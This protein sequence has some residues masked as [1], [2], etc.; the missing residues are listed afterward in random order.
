[1]HMRLL[2]CYAPLFSYGLL[3]DEQAGTPAGAGEL[4]LVQARARDIVHEARSRALAEG[5]PLTDVEMAAFAAV[6]WFDEVVMRQRAWKN[7]AG[8]LQSEL[9]NTAEAASE[10]FDLLA[11]LP[12]HAEE[13]R[14]VFSMAL[15]LGYAGQYYYEEGDS[16]ELGRI[17]ALYCRPRTTASSLLQSLQRE[18]VTPQP[19]AAPGLPTLHL[20]SSW[21]GRRSMQ[22]VAATIVLLVLVS[23]VAPAY[24][25]SIPAQVWYVLGLGLAVVC[26]MGWGLALA[27]HRLVAMRAHTRVAAHPDAGYGIGDLWGAVME[28]T[29]RVRGAVL[30]PFRRRGRWRRLSRHPWVMFL[31]DSPAEVRSLLQAA[32]HAPHARTQ[33]GNGASTPWHWWTFRSVVAL[34]PGGRI[35]QLTGQARDA[36][37]PWSQALSLLARERRKLPLDGIV[38][39]IAAQ[40]LQESPAQVSLRAERLREMASEAARHL[41]LQLPLYV[42]VTGMESLPGHATF[43]TTLPSAA[44]RRVLGVRISRAPGPYPSGRMDLPAD[45]LHAR[46]KDAAVAALA[47]QRDA[48][49]RREI[50]SFLQSLPGLQR[51]LRIFLD[52]LMVSDQAGDRRLLW[53]GLYLTGGA[54]SNAPGGDFVDD[55]FGRFLPADRLLAR[56]LAIEN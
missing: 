16:G 42:V 31:G 5:K 24:I 26:T 20:P 33:S 38:I 52:R 34:E 45:D 15:L 23:F 14:E 17:R 22:F 21:T 3:I 39:C 13:V 2:E 46:L 47:V 10:F 56:R 9:F 49:R 43:R 40:T 55:L 37:S 11:R 30:H 6:A 1:M 4:A 48:Q 7:Q 25:H 41:Q 54:R 53:C 35:V 29:R 50:F 51:G 32:A 44:F 12:A 36:A 8:A 19:Y 27:W 28:A 18:P